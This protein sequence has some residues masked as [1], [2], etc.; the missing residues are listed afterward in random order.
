M[1]RTKRLKRCAFCG[2]KIKG[3]GAQRNGKWF[4]CPWHADHYRPPP[5]WWKRLFARPQGE[6]GGGGN[7]C[8]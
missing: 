2:D 1:E 8:A 3:Q 5:P 7:C 6:P 4:C